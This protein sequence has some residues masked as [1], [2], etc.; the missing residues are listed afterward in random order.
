MCLH[1][2]TEGHVISEKVLSSLGNVS[3]PL[4]D[5]TA[6]FIK[7]CNSFGT[8]SNNV[9]LLFIYTGKSS[10]SSLQHRNEEA[11][12]CIVNEKKTCHRL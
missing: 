9:T 1:F 2:L 6:G 7:F 8:H 3:L 12:S 11:S 10:A 5:G 4:W